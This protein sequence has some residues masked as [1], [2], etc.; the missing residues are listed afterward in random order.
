[1]R[2]RRRARRAH[3]LCSAAVLTLPACICWCGRCLCAGRF[4]EKTELSHD[5]H[6]LPPEL[7][8]EIV[9]IIRRRNPELSTASGEI[10]IDID[11]LDTRTLRQMEKYVRE[12]LHKPWGPPAAPAV[13]KEKKVLSAMHHAVRSGPRCAVAERSLPL[14]CVAAGT[15]PQ[16]PAAPK[17]K[18]AV[19]SDSESDS[20]D[21]DSGSDSES[22]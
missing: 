10:E 15:W 22:S 11:S 16:K 5:I 20:S 4:D 7:L 9:D 2:S 3:P 18:A 19:S 14:G 1:M 17:K 12:Q 21:D 8:G 13:P 6:R